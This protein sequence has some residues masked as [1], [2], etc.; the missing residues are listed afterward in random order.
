MKTLIYGFGP[1]KRYKENISEKVI[2]KLAIDVP[3][4]TNMKELITKFSHS[5][6]ER[7]L[8]FIKNL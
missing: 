5:K 3:E 4:K 8:N 1:Y 6:M 2:K 7:E